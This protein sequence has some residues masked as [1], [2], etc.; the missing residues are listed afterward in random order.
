[1]VSADVNSRMRNVAISAL[2][3]IS[4]ASISVCEAVAAEGVHDA[5]FSVLRATKNKY[6]TMLATELLARLVEAPNSRQPLI[7]VGVIDV[8]LAQIDPIA[9]FEAYRAAEA[10][11][12]LVS[13]ASISAQYPIYL[14]ST[15]CRAPP[16][17]ICSRGGY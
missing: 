10:L 16:E 15:P 5:L 11:N 7:D 17:F 12:A 1:M 4:R 3:N 13:I 9:S 14:L 8:L 6:A 2:L